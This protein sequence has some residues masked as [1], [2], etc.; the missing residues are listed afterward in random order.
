MPDPLKHFM[1]VMEDGST[2]CSHI[3]KN[4]D[5]GHL[6]MCGERCDPESCEDT[7]GCEMCGC[8]PFCDK[9]TRSQMHDFSI[10]LSGFTPNYS[11]C[12]NNE[13]WLGQY[14]SI[15]GPSGLATLSHTERIGA[16]LSG[17]STG[18]DQHQRPN[19][20][21]WI[22]PDINGTYA[23]PFTAMGA[24][25]IRGRTLTRCCYESNIG[26]VAVRI[27]DTDDPRHFVGYSPQ[28]AISGLKKYV[29]NGAD[30]RTMEDICSIEGPIPTVPY[31]SCI[32]G[33]MEYFYNY[34][35]NYCNLTGTAKVQY[36]ANNLKGRDEAAI[37]CIGTTAWYLNHTLHFSLVMRNQNA[38][39][40]DPLASNPSDPSFPTA[41]D[42]VKV[43]LWFGQNFTHGGVIGPCSPSD[44]GSARRYISSGGTDY[45]WLNDPLNDIWELG[46]NVFY[47]YTNSFNCLGNTTFSN[48]ITGGGIIDRG[49]RATDDRGGWPSI[50]Y[51]NP[52]YV[53]GTVTINFLPCERVQGSDFMGGGG[54]PNLAKDYW[55]L[56]GGKRCGSSEGSWAS[57]FGE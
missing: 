9:N 5:T 35:K 33:G 28:Q 39:W 47:G 19:R 55:E 31:D 42:G 20:T 12:D 43:F 3:G 49:I 41:P 53:G 18:R 51:F 13:W 34:A 45:E 48:Q 11:W 21:M 30:T 23:L 17:K 50:R 52:L 1:R 54:D 38:H 16:A 56:Y 40:A 36:W 57:A 10:T 32:E 37:K 14:P 25:L 29:Y 24:N 26:S 22:H 7:D 8:E 2:T 27:G 15:T 46:S 44:S 6:T 4:T